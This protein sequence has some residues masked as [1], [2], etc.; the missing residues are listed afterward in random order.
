MDSLTEVLLMTALDKARQ[1]YPSASI[2]VV[3]PKFGPLC[4][5]VPNT[6]T[7]HVRLMV[8]DSLAFPHRRIL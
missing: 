5:F 2:S 7:H 4:G 3:S 8:D 1:V 6:S